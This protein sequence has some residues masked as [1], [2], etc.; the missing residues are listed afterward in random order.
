MTASPYSVRLSADTKAKLEKWA[1]RHERPLSFLV[2]KA[3][4][5]YI[6]DLEQ[7]D[8]S[9]AAAEAELDKGIFTSWEN[10]KV[11]M[12]SWDTDNELPMPEPDIF[13]DIHQNMPV[14]GK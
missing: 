4:D 8:R 12:D 14:T 11:W 6:E 1:E 10:V 9:M 2:Q 7:F 3:L 13:P 5:N